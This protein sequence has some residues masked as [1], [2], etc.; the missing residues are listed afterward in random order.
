MGLFSE[1]KLAVPWGHIAAK[2]WGSQ[3][4]LPVLCLHGWLD[5][6]NSF[7]RLIPLLPKDFQYV[8]MDFGGHGLSSHYSPG[9]PYY[10][11]NFVSEIRRVT[12][13]LK[14]NR[15]SLMGHSFGWGEQEAGDVSGEGRAS[16][17]HQCHWLVP[18]CGCTAVAASAREF[19]CLFPEMVDK[20]ILLDSSPLTLDTKAPEE[21]SSRGRGVW[22]TPPAERSHAGGRRP[23]AEQGPEDHLAAALP[24]VHQQGAV[25][26]RHQEAAGPR[27][28]HQHLARSKPTTSG[29]KAVKT[30]S[31]GLK[32]TLH[33]TEPSWAITCPRQELCLLGTHLRGQAQGWRKHGPRCKS[34]PQ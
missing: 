8:A 29:C 22:E 1:L 24:G 30:L 13:A 15:F 5:N 33:S 16:S 9:F 6:A 23:G 4:G 11:Q 10:Q 28:A 3:Q 18:V 17:H 12:A 21:Q 26:A 7:D 2:V 27:P 25:C 19:S 20:L 34:K 31:C 14:W 32:A